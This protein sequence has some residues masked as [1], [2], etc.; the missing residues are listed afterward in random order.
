MK[1]RAISKDCRLS[2]KTLRLIVDEV[3][4]KRVEEALI[5]LRFMPSPAARMVA[6]T[7]KSAAANAENNYQLLHSELKVV[8]IF[9]DKGHVAKRFRPQA[10]GRSA[11]IL[12]QY[13][14]ISVV[15]AGEEA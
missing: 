14:H 6:K 1:V 2:T 10:R 4:G 8:E 3:R 7:V 12:K 9:V 15:V 11:P 5:T 13:S